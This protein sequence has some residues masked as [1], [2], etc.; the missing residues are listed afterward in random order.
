MFWWMEK[1]LDWI[2]EEKHDDKTA[3]GREHSISMHILSLETK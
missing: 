2:H 1:D 3:Y